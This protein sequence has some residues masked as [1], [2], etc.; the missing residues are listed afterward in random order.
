MRLKSEEVGFKSHETEKTRIRPSTA[1][2]G[3][4]E[5]NPTPNT[6]FSIVDAALV[7]LRGQ[8]K[9]HERFDQYFGR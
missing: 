2:P 3:P 8:Q 4:A 6:I 5:E 1:P 7:V 9:N